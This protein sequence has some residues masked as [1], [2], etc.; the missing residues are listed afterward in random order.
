MNA[1][2]SGEIVTAAQVAAAVAD[3]CNNPRME[4]ALRLYLE[5]TERSGFRF[6]RVLSGS[7]EGTP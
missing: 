6:V 5:A 4:G 1:Q 7:S 3:D 2:P